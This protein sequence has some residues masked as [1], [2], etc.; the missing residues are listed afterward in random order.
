MDKSRINNLI[1]EFEFAARASE[2][3]LESMED[4]RSVLNRYYE[5]YREIMAIKNELNENGIIDSLTTISTNV[6]TLNAQ[7][8][9]EIKEISSSVVNVEENV[10]SQQAKVEKTLKSLEQFQMSISDIERILSKVEKL[11]QHFNPANIYQ[12]DNSLTTMMKTVELIENKVA[13]VN[14]QFTYHLNELET[15]I[16]KKEEWFNNSVTEKMNHIDEIVQVR[17]KALLEFFSEAKIGIDESN[18]SVS[19]IIE[20]Y[21]SYSSKFNKDVNE[22]V[23]INQSLASTLSGLG[24]QNEDAFDIL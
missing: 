17:E 3:M 24:K 14:N 6:H 20:G 2:T 9:K 13:W 5:S 12:F 23:S 11:D 1:D 7:L 4:L 16:N 15:F 19:R 22:L 10:V 8:S 21:E 18:A